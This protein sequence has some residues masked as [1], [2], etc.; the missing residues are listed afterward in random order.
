MSQTYF[1]IINVIAIKYRILALTI[2][3]II[4]LL[5]CVPKNTNNAIHLEKISP[6]LKLLTHQTID[7]NLF[8][9]YGNTNEEV[10]SILISSQE[11]DVFIPI[12]R[13]EEIRLNNTTVRAWYTGSIIHFL[14]SQNLKNIY[15]KGDLTNEFNKEK[16][17]EIVNFLMNSNVNL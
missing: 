14:W 2:I 4:L 13:V 6:S 16:Y 3:T 9:T 15:L 12:D 1:G 17:L 10:L 11:L 7:Q 5:G 8:Y